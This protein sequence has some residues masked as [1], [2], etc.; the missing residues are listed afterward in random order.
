M[1]GTLKNLHFFVRFGGQEQGFS[2]PDRGSRATWADH[3][4]KSIFD[5]F[6]DGFGSQVGTM[7]GNN[8][9][10]FWLRSPPRGRQERYGSVL[11]G[12]RKHTST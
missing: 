7:L 11:K 1:I 3:Q 4:K 10:F 2:V 5:R 6:L 8:I 12:C 9:L